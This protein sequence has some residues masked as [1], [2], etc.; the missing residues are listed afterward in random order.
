VTVL[1]CV[2]AIA[3]PPAGACER[4]GHALVLPARGG[5]AVLVEVGD[6]GD[7]RVWMCIHSHEGA[8]DDRG[9]P[10]WGGLQMDRSF[11]QA[12]G[13]DMIRRHH[14]GLADSWTPREQM[15]VAERARRTRGYGP[16]PNTRKP[17]H[18]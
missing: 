11:M 15:V 1:L 3:T 6:P 16:W 7:V 12:Y 4:G 17:C 14:G 13:R 8:W 9:D 10:Y 18:V 2:L 5:H